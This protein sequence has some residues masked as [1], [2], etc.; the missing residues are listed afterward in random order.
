LSARLFRQ[1]VYYRRLLT[2][3]GSEVNVKD[4]GRRH[5]AALKHLVSGATKRAESC[6]IG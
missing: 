4:Y 1:E 2:K 3:L 6:R 5:G